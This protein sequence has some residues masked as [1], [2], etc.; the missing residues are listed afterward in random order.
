M[1]KYSIDQ[2]YVNEEGLIY[3]LQNLS[4]DETPTTNINGINGVNGIQPPM[5]PPMLW[6]EVPDH[7]CYYS[8]EYNKIDMA[9][10]DCHTEKLFGNIQPKSKNIIV[11]H[12]RVLVKLK[13]LPKFDTLKSFVKFS[14]LIWS[15]NI[16]KKV[17]EA[18]SGNMFVSEFVGMRPYGL[19]REGHCVIETYCVDL[20]VNKPYQ[21]ISHD[22]SMIG[23]KRIADNSDNSDPLDIYFDDRNYFITL[24][25]DDY[26]DSRYANLVSAQ[27][28]H[29]SLD[30]KFEKIEN[31]ALNKLAAF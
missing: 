11:L 8:Y 25:L 28:Y 24:F 5:Q 21:I 23:R 9:H 27:I 7:V 14:V 19:L 26:C 4:S 12:S 3:S 30:F 15:S 13:I 22:D 31:I 2:D 1:S 10:N 20:N 18:R 17:S 16:F 6:K 29:E